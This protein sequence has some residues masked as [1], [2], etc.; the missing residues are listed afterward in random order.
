MKKFLFVLSFIMG[1]IILSV[2][3]FS[4][5]SVEI[6]ITANTPPPELPEY[7]QPECPEDGFMWTPGYWGYGDDGYYWVP[8]FWVSPPQP[9]YLWTPCYWGLIGG[10][11]SWN[12][13]YWG[14]HVGFYGGV[15]YGYGYGGHGFGGGRW[16]RGRFRYNAAV[17][18]VNRTVIHNTYIDRTVIAHRSIN[19]RTSFNGGDHGTKATP[20]ER[21]RF[22]MKE[23]HIAPTGNQ[24]FH[25]QNAARDKNQ[26]ASANHGRPI[27]TSMNTVGGNRK[28]TLL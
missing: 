24:A 16:D 19:N 25:E 15:N 21:E 8:G 18:N 6:S 13:G 10:I 1:I 23:T 17:M 9:G 20:S 3:A 26:F 28:D 5:I 27:T 12:R 4:Q 11:Y 2:K 7:I 14:E 22:T